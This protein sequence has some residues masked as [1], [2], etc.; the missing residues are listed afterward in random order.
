MIVLSSRR[1]LSA[2]QSGASSK[3]IFRAHFGEKNWRDWDTIVA[4]HPAQGLSKGGIKPRTVFEMM[5]TDAWTA[6]GI[7]IWW[8]PVGIA[9]AVESKRGLFGQ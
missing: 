4:E 3:R 8:D 7:V 9:E 1:A 6:D 5:M 2:G